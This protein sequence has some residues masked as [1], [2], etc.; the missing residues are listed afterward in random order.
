MAENLKVRVETTDENVV[1]TLP[2]TKC[3]AKYRRATR[4]PWLTL[5]HARGDDSSPI[6]EV[7][8]HARAWQL[9]SE[10]ARELGWIV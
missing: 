1:V 5:F 4:L 9:A 10:K 8:F 3:M 7:R 6:H 2:G